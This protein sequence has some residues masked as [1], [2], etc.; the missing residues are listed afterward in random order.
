MPVIIPKE[1]EDIWL[2]VETK[3]VSCLL[4]ILKPYPADEMKYKT[5]SEIK[6]FK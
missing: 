6:E 4:S 3:D 5:G 2:A 1:Q